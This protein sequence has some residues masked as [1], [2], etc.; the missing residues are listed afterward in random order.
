MTDLDLD[1]PAAAR[2]AHVLWRA[3]GPHV[4]E[5][6]EATGPPG[7]PVRLRMEDGATPLAVLL[8]RGLTLGEAITILIP[9]AEAIAA[10]PGEV[11]HGAIG[12]EAI[13]L[14]GSG[15]PILT[16]FRPPVA[17]D[18]LP[19]WGS[20][21][22]AGVADRAAFRE[23]ARVVLGAVVA[24][25][26]AQVERVALASAV[27]D[28]VDPERPATLAALGDRLLAIATPES[29]RLGAASVA[30]DRPAG[31]P[32]AR[33]EVPVAHLRQSIRDIRASVRARLGSVRPRFWVPAVLVLVG[34]GVVV[35]L[36]PSGND[37]GRPL[38]P[39]SPSTPADVVDTAPAVA[40]A[41]PAEDPVDAAIALRPEANG[42]VVVD[43][44]GDIVLVRL[45]TASGSEEVLIERTD[46][47][48]RLRE[49][50][51]SGG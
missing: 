28:E 30:Q 20:L 27:V 10:L 16:A 32:V 1:P 46:A 11:V 3:R 41:P 45:D 13:R 31:M 17:V 44:Y 29:V 6:V 19:P 43:D 34:L 22:E 18:D 24:T 35:G 8:E 15:A 26:G 14:D 37:G 12:I 4:A 25:P 33:V 48:W 51:A 7:G 39:P 36:L 2:L 49:A 42:G 40:D 21:A 5:I 23:L 38:A 50:E 9:I 47:G